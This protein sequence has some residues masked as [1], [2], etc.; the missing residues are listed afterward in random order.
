MGRTKERAPSRTDVM[1]Y[2]PY[3]SEATFGGPVPMSS[4][5]L[6]PNR[7]HRLAV[8]D[9][10]RMGET[11]ILPVDGRM[12]LIEGEIIVIAPIGSRHA[13]IVKQ[14][15]ALFVRAVGAGAVVSVQD[16]IILGEYSE[17]E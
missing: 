6:D 11:G 10:H 17:P 1:L 13:A 7:K 15:M 5:A 3:F 14:L 9:F 16:P 8:H 2:F 12:E 4:P